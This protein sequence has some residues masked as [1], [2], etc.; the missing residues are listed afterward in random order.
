VQ[1]SVNISLHR[2]WFERK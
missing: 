2:I 1:E